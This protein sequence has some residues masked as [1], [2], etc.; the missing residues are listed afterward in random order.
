MTEQISCFP[1]SFYHNCFIDNVHNNITF[2]DATIA[3]VWNDSYPS[4]GNYWSDYA[5]NDACSGP[6]QNVTGSDN[7]GD[8]SHVVSCN[9]TDNKDYYPIMSPD[10]RLAVK[11]MYLGTELYNVSVWIDGGEELL[12]P[13]NVT[14]VWGLH[15]VEVDQSFIVPIDEW[16]YYRYT[17][18][19]WED[20]S[21]DNPR[22]ESTY[23]RATLTAYY[24]RR[25]IGVGK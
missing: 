8:T 19:H 11:T 20:Y 9:N 16:S 22:L 21:T 4:S 25:I 1:H 23:A 18:V 5:G 12:S 14:V 7:I 17:F 13:V 6:Y 2:W 3:H 24:T 10:S 15:E